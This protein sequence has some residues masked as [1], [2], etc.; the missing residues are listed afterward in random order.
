[1][2]GREPN[3]IEATLRATKQKISMWQ[4]VGVQPHFLVLG[5]F[6]AEDSFSM[7]VAIL[8]LLKSLESGRYNPANNL[9][10]SAS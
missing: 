2:W 8:M 6:L 4:L 10:Q 9:K 3:T 7:H 5:P 1:V